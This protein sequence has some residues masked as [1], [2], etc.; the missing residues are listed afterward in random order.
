MSDSLYV[1]GDEPQSN[2]A[3]LFSHLV[4]LYAADISPELS[5]IAQKYPIL[6]KF[7][8]QI[9]QKYFRENLDP[10][11]KVISSYFPIRH[12]PQQSNR[13]LL[14]SLENKPPSKGKWDPFQ[15]EIQL[16]FSSSFNSDSSPEIPPTADSSALNDSATTPTFLLPSLQDIRTFHSPKSAS[17]LEQNRFYISLNGILFSMF[18]IGSFAYP[19]VVRRIAR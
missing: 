4:T 11:A 10:S 9:C 3:L 17:R 2:D 18:V 12:L 15:K 7:F 14:K 1:D 19:F 5:A 16:V 8:D 6:Q 13:V